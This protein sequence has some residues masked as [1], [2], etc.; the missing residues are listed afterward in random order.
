MLVPSALARASARRR[1][2]RWAWKW[3]PKACDEDRRRDRRLGADQRRRLRLSAHRRAGARIR[4]R[5][6]LRH[7]RR[8]SQRAVADLS[9][10]P[11]GDGERARGRPPHRPPRRRSTSIS[12]PK[13]RSAGRRAAIA[14]TAACRSRPATTPAFPNMSRARL[15]APLGWSYAYLRRF[16]AP[17]ERI[18]APTPS[19]KRELERRGFDRMSSFGRAAS[20]TRCSGRAPAPRSICR[21]RSSSMS[22]AWRWRR[23]SEAF[24]DLDLPGSKVVVGDGPGRAAAA[25]QIPGRAF[26]R[27]EIRRR[28]RRSLRLGRR[29]RVSLAHRHV[30]RRA[31]RGAG[32]RPAG[33]RLSR[34]RAARRDRR[35]PAPARS[36]AICAAPASPR[37][38]F[39]ASGR[40]RARWRTPGANRRAS[41][42]ST[43]A[44]RRSREPAAPAIPPA[45]AP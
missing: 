1:R 9:R 6:R 30:R 7:A 31:D 13:G 42:S 33:R 41:S 2:R 11:A 20:I 29:V 44:A 32:E 23:T 16:H 45:S 4:R 27:R 38:T 25:A 8:L 10:H 18:L 34:H 35:Q 21:G 22:A 14:S 3:G 37:S 39:R 36:T 17:A 19:M 26:P 40:G 28:T 12:P 24:L 43:S 5:T 15:P